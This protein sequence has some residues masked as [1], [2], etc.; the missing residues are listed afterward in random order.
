[1]LSSRDR[2]GGG[3]PERRGEFEGTL[4]SS[5]GSW[6]PFFGGGS[7]IRKVKSNLRSHS[8]SVA[9]LGLKFGLQTPSLCI[10][11]PGGRRAGKGDVQRV[12]RRVERRGP[13]TDQAKLIVRG[14]QYSKEPTS[15]APF[16]SC[17]GLHP[18]SLEN[19]DVPPPSPLSQGTSRLVLVSGTGKP[20]GTG[21]LAGSVV[22]L[23]LPVQPGR[24]QTSR[25]PPDSQ[26][27]M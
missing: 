15:P 18:N 22:R 8:P 14:K 5:K 25:G 1:M 17:P 3:R 6:L 13:L 4:P 19:V 11:P 16:V 27:H 12:E 2:V 24:P 10:T 21:A 20:A 7:R 9:E 23:F 26:T